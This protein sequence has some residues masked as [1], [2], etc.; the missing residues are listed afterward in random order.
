MIVSAFE[1]TYVAYCRGKKRFVEE[2]KGGG[3]VG[4]KRKINK[5][6]KIKE[7]MRRQMLKEK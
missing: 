2:K 6:Q 4:M 1:K 7:K 5:T 3:K